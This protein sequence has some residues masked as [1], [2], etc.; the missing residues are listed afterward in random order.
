MP[1]QGSVFALAERKTGNVSLVKDNSLKIRGFFLKKN[2]KYNYTPRH[3]NGKEVGNV[4]ELG[5]RIRKYHDTPNT[6]HYTEQWKELRMQS[7]NRGN[8]EINKTLIIVLIV[9]VL[10]VLYIFDFDLSF[11]TTSK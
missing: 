10:L 9:L 1:R 6:N 8:R 3:Y 4:Y 7:R 11:F 2:K 5:S